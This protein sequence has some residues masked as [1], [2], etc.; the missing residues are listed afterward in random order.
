[1]ALYATLASNDV[2]VCLIPEQPFDIDKLCH[3]IGPVCVFVCACVCARVCCLSSMCMSM[4]VGVCLVY[5][6]VCLVY[7]GVCLGSAG[8]DGDSRRAGETIDRKGHCVI[9]VAEGAGSEHFEV[10]WAIV[11]GQGV[12]CDVGS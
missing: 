6:G 3:H 11:D 9:V 5:T 4:C 12:W 8:S 7:I 1:V 2:D 10:R